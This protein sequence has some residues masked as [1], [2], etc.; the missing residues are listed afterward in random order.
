MDKGPE[1]TSWQTPAGRETQV[2]LDEATAAERTATRN[3]IH[4]EILFTKV[5]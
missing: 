3:I 2:T 4:E 1:E 5:R